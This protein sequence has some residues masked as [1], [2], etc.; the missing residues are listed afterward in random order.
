MLRCVECGSTASEHLP[1]WRAY[2]AEPDESDGGGSSVVV[3]CPECAAREFG[4][5]GAAS[6]LPPQGDV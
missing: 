3:Y 6:E 4:P 2:I 5:Q 1:N